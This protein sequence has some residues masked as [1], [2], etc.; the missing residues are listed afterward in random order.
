MACVLFLLCQT[1][2]TH[3]G[4][5]INSRHVLS[6]ITFKIISASLLNNVN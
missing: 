4:E 3:E 1:W 6:Y 2:V 5:K